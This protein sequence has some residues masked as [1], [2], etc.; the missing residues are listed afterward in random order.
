MAAL[1]ERHKARPESWRDRMRLVEA[2]RHLASTA[3]SRTHAIEH[4]EKGRELLD[5]RSMSLRTLEQRNAVRIE[6]ASHLIEEIEAE[7]WADEV[8]GKS[9]S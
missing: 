8:W 6:L 2:Y 3:T 5:R 9:D 7:S 1:K 4:L